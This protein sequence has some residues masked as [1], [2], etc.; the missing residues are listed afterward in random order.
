MG[1]HDVWI[2]WVSIGKLKPEEVY[3]LETK[4][5]TKDVPLQDYNLND[6][7]PANYD[8]PKLP[9]YVKDSTED[10]TA[11]QFQA[12]NHK[13][14]ATYDCEVI[15]GVTF[16]TVTNRR[17]GNINLTVTKDW[18]V[19]DSP[20]RDEIKQELERIKAEKGID[21]VLALQLNFM[22]EETPSYYE[23]TRSAYKLCQVSGF[24][25]KRVDA[26]VRK[27]DTPMNS[28]MRIHGAIYAALDLSLIHI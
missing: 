4:V 10:Y 20:L 12:T 11:I 7:D 16:Y 28:P 23:I 8:E 25:F 6:K 2:D 5:G 27:G 15:E 18:Y 19:G 26:I 17:L 24:G 13:Y 1:E 14:E 22:E 21:L 3:I 9:I